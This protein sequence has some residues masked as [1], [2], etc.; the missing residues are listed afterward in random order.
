MNSTNP[1]GGPGAPVPQERGATPSSPAG[2]GKPDLVVTGVAAAALGSRAAAAAAAAAGAP[3]RPSDSAATD[4]LALRVSR[5]NA[6]LVAA[7]GA[8]G[9]LSDALAQQL[10]TQFNWTDVQFDGNLTGRM[11][12]QMTACQLFV[13]NQV[14]N[15]MMDE[16]ERLSDLGRGLAVQG[17]RH[18]IGQHETSEA[19]T[20]GAVAGEEEA[21]FQAIVAQKDA[22]LGRMKLETAAK[23]RF[24]EAEAAAAARQRDL[25]GRLDE[26]NGQ[27]TELRAQ[28]E[29][30][31]QRQLAAQKELAGKLGDAMEKMDKLGT[32]KER[33]QRAR[34]VQAALS[35]LQTV[36]FGWE[37]LLAF[38]GTALFNILTS[39]E[40][41]GM[42]T[43]T[44]KVAGALVGLTGGSTASDRG[45]SASDVAAAQ[46]DMPIGS[47]GRSASPSQVVGQDKKK[48]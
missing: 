32:D 42:L 4:Q 36:N 11:L 48:A 5:E 10:S 18:A 34:L 30:D 33:M 13:A 6:Q 19:T 40:L 16:L 15:I 29:R 45:P 23:V 35:T 38:G 17:K 12:T 44:G 26:A 1:I 41:Y 43:T 31:A 46:A 47:T 25:E 28:M 37:P 14:F 7:G 22:D 21:G 20:R 8:V 24:T 3:V 27:V 2:T 9:V 39:D